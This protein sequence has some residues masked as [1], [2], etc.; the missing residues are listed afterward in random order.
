[1]SLCFQGGM[2][3]LQQVSN[4]LASKK[5]STF[6]RE[7][8]VNWCLHSAVRKWAVAPGNGTRV[9]TEYIH[10]YLHL[11]SLAPLLP[12]GTA[13]FP[14]FDLALAVGNCHPDQ[15]PHLMHLLQMSYLFNVCLLVIFFHGAPMFFHF[16]FHSYPSLRP[17]QSINN[18]P[19]SS[20]HINSQ[21]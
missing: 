19:S 10:Y 2:S 6:V 13:H 4:A 17:S 12:H 3:G 14:V 16:F 11:T 15:S 18:P 1:M 5:F 20:F 7:A 8:G 9:S 21:S